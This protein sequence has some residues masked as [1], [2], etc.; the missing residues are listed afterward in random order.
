VGEALAAGAAG[1]AVIRGV[2]GATDPAGAL[3]RYLQ[4]FDER[5]RNPGREP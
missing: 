1:V 5:D 4:A 3:L 2:W